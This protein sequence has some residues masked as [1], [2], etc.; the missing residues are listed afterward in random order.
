MKAVSL[1]NRAIVRPLLIFSKPNVNLS[2]INFWRWKNPRAKQ[3]RLHYSY[4]KFTHMLFALRRNI[5]LFER[6]FGRYTL[7]QSYTSFFYIGI[8]EIWIF[9]IVAKVFGK[10][11]ANKN[12]SIS[13]LI[14]VC[15]YFT[16]ITQTSCIEYKNPLN[17]RVRRVA[18]IN[19]GTFSL[20]IYTLVYCKNWK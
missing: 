16:L 19:A 10:M 18:Q 14:H 15:V 1:Y 11:D 9:Y 5:F 7:F 12:I 3:I 17:F 2:K 8:L 20:S 4:Y 13:F 6:Q